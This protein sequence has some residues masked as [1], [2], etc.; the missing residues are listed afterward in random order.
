MESFLD[1]PEAI[2]NT[3]KLAD[4]VDL[5]IKLGEWYFPEF[6]LPKDKTAGEVL[7]EMAY[8]GAKEKF[9]E[10]TRRYQK[11]GL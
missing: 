7:R 6:E 9:G 4:K 3:V 8:S 2:E 5:E 11:I 10:V 1:L